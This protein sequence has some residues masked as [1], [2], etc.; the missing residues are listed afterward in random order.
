[1]L[2]QCQTKV[3]QY[4]NGHPVLSQCRVRHTVQLAVIMMCV[5]LSCL[6]SLEFADR[7]TE[8]SPKPVLIKNNPYEFL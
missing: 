5:H 8:Q 2:P 3:S 1:M 7:R 4:P 6:G